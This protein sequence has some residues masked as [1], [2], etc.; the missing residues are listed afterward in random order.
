MDGKYYVYY[1]GNYVWSHFE[2]R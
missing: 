2:A 1:A